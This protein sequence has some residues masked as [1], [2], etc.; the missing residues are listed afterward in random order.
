[1]NDARRVS[2]SSEAIVCVPTNSFRVSRGAL[3]QRD[4]AK[5]HDA[6]RRNNKPGNEAGGAAPEPSRGVTGDWINRGDSGAVGFARRVV[7]RYL[8]GETYISDLSNLNYPMMRRMMDTIRERAVKSGLERVAV[9]LE[10][11]TKD[12]LDFSDIERLVADVAHSNDV[13]TVT[14]T[15]IA[16]GLKN[17]SLQVRTA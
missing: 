17:G 8:R 15:E 2:K 5:A 4:V 12:V 11:H 7:R 13:T 14:L 3:L 16:N 10:N 6:L 1:M 9:I